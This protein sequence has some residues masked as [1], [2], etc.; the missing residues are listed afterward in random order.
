[1]FT[2]LDSYKL[3]KQR[4]EITLKNNLYIDKKLYLNKLN[5]LNNKIKNL[6]TEKSQLPLL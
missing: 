4:L 5:W 6:I 3:Q 1:M 2:N